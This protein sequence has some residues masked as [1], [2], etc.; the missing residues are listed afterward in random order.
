MIQRLFGAGILVLASLCLGRAS[1]RELRCKPERLR[2]MIDAL[3]RLRAEIAAFAPLRE[4]LQHASESPDESVRSFF[5]TIS[6][7]METENQRFQML[8]VSE[9]KK[10]RFLNQAEVQ[11]LM[12]LGAQLGRY[13]ADSQL[14]ALDRCIQALEQAYTEAKEKARSE[15]GLRLRLTAVIV[16]LVMIVI[17]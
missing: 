2:R 10:L 16:A 9:L 17:W 6:S 7:R 3:E 11:T 4:A 14:R 1:V 13:D 8:W 15:A 12:P 5:Y